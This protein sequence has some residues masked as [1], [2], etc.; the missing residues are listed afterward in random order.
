MSD[1]PSSLQSLQHQ[2]LRQAALQ[3]L[4]LPLP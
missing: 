4:P 2:K 1:G 3:T